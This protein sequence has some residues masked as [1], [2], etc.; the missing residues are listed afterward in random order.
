MCSTLSTFCRLI[1]SFQS[2]NR[3]CYNRVRVF[4]EVFACKSENNKFL[5]SSLTFK[6]FKV[7]NVRVYNAGFKD[8][9]NIHCF[10]ARLMEIS[11]VN[12]KH[13]Y[14]VLNC[15]LLLSLSVRTIIILEREKKKL[16]IL[17]LCILWCFASINMTHK[18]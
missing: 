2:Y 7:Q 18:F 4:V 12:Y 11:E 9:I 16:Y 5:P 14:S 3:I 13:Q 10:A 8:V 17:E 1:P 15:T 6:R